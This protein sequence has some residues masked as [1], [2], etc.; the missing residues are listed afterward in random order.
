MDAEL[1]RRLG[2][3]AR[4][5]DL[6][7]GR[8]ETLLP[9]SA[10]ADL[11]IYLYWSAVARDADDGR[12]VFSRQGGGTRVGE[13]PGRQAAADLERPGGTRASSATPS[14][15]ADLV[16]LVAVGLRQ[17]PAARARP[18]GSATA[19]CTALIQTRHSAD[20]TG[21]PVHTGRRQPADV[22]G[23]RDAAAWT[24]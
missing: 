14:L 2:W 23:R 10:V 1:A 16:G 5:V 12:T 7:A 22:L 17:R 4:R 11:L 8:Y 13:R 9:P 19:S 20:L 24:R 6:D 3:A 21:L 18:T 15:M